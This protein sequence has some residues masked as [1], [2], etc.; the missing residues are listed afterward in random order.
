M[1]GDTDNFTRPVTL[2]SVGR[3]RL[4]RRLG[5][6]G[7]GEVYLADD[8]LLNRTIALKLLAPDVAGDPERRQFFQREATSAAALNHPNICTIFEVGEADNRPYI[9][10][11]AVEGR[12]LAAMQQDGR[13]PVE[14]TLSIGLQV[15]SAL[16]EARE[17][18]VVHR[19]LKSANIMV[20]PKGTVKVLDFGLAK[21]V[22]ANTSPPEQTT[23]WASR[24]DIVFGTLPYMS[25][26]QALGRAVDHR[27]DL[28]SLGTILYEALTGRM[29]FEGPT[30]PEVLNAIV[31]RPTEPIRKRNPR[32]SPAVEVVV[33]KLL[34]KEPA[35]RYQTAAEVVDD[36]RAIQTTGDLAWGRTT[37]SRRLMIAA[38]VATMAIGVVSGVAWWRTHAIRVAST[39]PAVQTLVV[40]PATIAGPPQFQFLADAIANSLTTRLSGT[41]G[42]AMKVPP[43]S[44]EFSN[45]GGSLV[46]VADSYGV[47][48]CIV[49]HATISGE[50]L[51][52]TVQVVE[53]KRRD[54]VWSG[55]FESPIDRYADAVAQAA[56]G[57]SF[58]LTGRRPSS[59][60]GVPR[61]SA[62][63]LSIGRGEYYG[64]IFNARYQQSD[65][66][67]AH[68]AYED[69]LQSDPRSS[70]AA[71]GLAYL[72][73]FRMQGG[74]PPSRS[75]PEL[76]LWAHR[77]IE[78]D[79]RHPLGWAAL[80][81]GESWR[82]PADLVKQL[83]YGFRAA[84][85]GDTCGK[86]QLS[87]MMGVQHVSAVLKHHIALRDADLDPLSAYGYINSAAALTTLGRTDEAA[88]AIAR[89]T[90]IEP[91][92]LWVAALRA[93][94]H[95]AAGSF[96]AAA[97]D[98]DALAA[99]D[100]ITS[101]PAWVGR[102]LDLIHA[103]AKGDGGAIASAVS[104]L[105]EPAPQHRAVEEELGYL[106]NTV[107]P[108]LG[109]AG[110]M[111]D[112]LAVMA[113]ATAAGAP[114][115]YDMV[116]MN[117]Y[118]RPLLKDPRAQRIVD[119]SHQEF[120][121]LLAAIGEARGA[122]RF[123]RYLEQPLQDLLSAVSSTRP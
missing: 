44:S 113:D 16:E 50:R 45:V 63:E 76:D 115:A 122:G 13:L 104:R 74:G 23:A 37:V 68:A 38:A 92:A 12:T 105:R 40:V 3:Y 1:G 121:V 103:E 19:D 59:A 112:A 55:E 70:A 33:A 75:M 28:F 56:D 98:A 24:T 79:P 20:T 11:E 85:F 84:T 17:R 123:P 25:P 91:D 64:R 96:D 77:A 117:P 15:A 90:A 54:I 27:S 47:S 30:T 80:A 94:V 21:R 46:R 93:F 51:V 14:T 69:A 42:V 9:A 26:E 97:A 34:A 36:L 5:H 31:N 120:G 32:V 110:R 118:L 6:G 53:P 87:L 86:C 52:V 71:A 88:A 39:I 62:A 8:P 119:R 7:M 108:I 41:G 35:D 100:S 95:A 111:D 61:N 57:L 73:I 102:I 60:P 67:R 107:A 22:G 18:N 29:P 2:G 58:A 106:A 66:G 10:M 82:T 89:A 81:V 83:D 109:R 65:Y 43:T 48:N 72:E 101:M 99:R 4:I 116:L 49:P 78:F 114:P